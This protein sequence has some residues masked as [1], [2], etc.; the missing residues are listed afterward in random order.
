MHLLS[1]T[2]LCWFLEPNFCGW[3]LVVRFVASWIQHI[4]SSSPWQIQIPRCHSK[5]WLLIRL[6]CSCPGNMHSWLSLSFIRCQFLFW[7][8]MPHGPTGWYLMQ[9]AIWEAHYLSI[10]MSAPS[11]TIMPVALQFILIH[12]LHF[13]PQFQTLLVSVLFLRSVSTYHTLREH[14]WSPASLAAS[15]FGWK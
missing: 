7:C 5:R 8:R 12:R 1:W 10:G 11:A 3:H 2:T 13:K 15:W 14:T 9:K 6:L 4:P